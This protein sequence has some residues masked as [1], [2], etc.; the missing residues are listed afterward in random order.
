MGVPSAAPRHA[1]DQVAAGAAGLGGG[2]VLADLEAEAADVVH[3]GVG[4]R[5][6]LTRGGADGDEPDEEVAQLV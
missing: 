3:H 5:A 4:H 1:H 2:V 6:L